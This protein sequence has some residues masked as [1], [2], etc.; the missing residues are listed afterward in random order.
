MWQLVDHINA[1]RKTQSLPAISLSPRLTAVAW[2]HAKDLATNR[3]NV[4]LGNLHSWSDD[5]RWNGGAYAPTD[6]STW[7]IM[8]EKPKEIAGY[9][10]FGFEI[11]AAG[12]RDMAHSLQLWKA[13]NAH[14]DVILNR[15]IWADSRWTWRALGA[16][17]YQGFA[18]AWFG[19][20]P[21]D[22]AGDE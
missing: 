14:H 8:W 17:F 19:N 11:C 2:L 15:G 22:A 20:Q 13:S 6:K 9:G 5:P 10:A 12:A 16:A 4:K 18:C 21:D 7:K 3:P 1:Y